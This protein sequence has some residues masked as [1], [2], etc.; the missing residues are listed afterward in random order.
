MASSSGN[1]SSAIANE[2]PEATSGIFRSGSSLLRG[3]GR[4]F[5][6]AS[7]YTALK[8]EPTRTE[9]IEG[10]SFQYAEL[11]YGAYTVGEGLLRFPEGSEL[12][13]I[14]SQMNVIYNTLDS[15]LIDFDFSTNSGVR[16]ANR[17]LQENISEI[18]REINRLLEEQ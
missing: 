3:F 1:I 15:Y 5:S 18:V 4:I 11:A 7:I 14:T 16:A 17:H 10:L 12:S 8:S 2:V 6:G 9:M 13:Q